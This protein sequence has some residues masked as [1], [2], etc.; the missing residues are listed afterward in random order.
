[1]LTT[2]PE[3]EHVAPDKAKSAS[4]KQ[5]LLLIDSHSRDG[6]TLTA[7]IT[8]RPQEDPFLRDHH[9]KGRPILPMVIGIEAL[10]EATLPLS[11]TRGEVIRMQNFRVIEPMRLLGDQ[12]A[13]ARVRCQPLGNRYTASLS[14]DFC[15]ASGKLLKPD[16][17]QM[18]GEVQFG[19]DISF[20]P[21]QSLQYT[22]IWNEVEYPDEQFVIYHGQSMRCLKKMNKDT[23]MLVVPPSSLLAGNRK[24]GEWQVAPNLLDACFYAM[25][26]VIWANNPQLVALPH[27]LAELLVGN[28]PAAGEECFLKWNILQ[29]QP[30]SWTFDFDLFNAQG[31]VFIQARGYET[32]IFEGPSA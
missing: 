17:L 23:A 30:N 29:R 5:Q 15:N 27:S 1:M 10:V 18:T 2:N 20:Y 31:D 22:P 19:P 25:G 12:P 32:T 26:I 24:R 28:I 6:E 21:V 7:E 4:S 11:A 16:R 14:S 13:T 8:F 3:G 9:L